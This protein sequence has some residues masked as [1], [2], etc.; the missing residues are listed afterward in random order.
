MMQNDMRMYFDSCLM[1]TK[2]YVFSFFNGSFKVI[3]SFIQTLEFS[4]LL[5][6]VLTRLDIRGSTLY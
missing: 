1:L 5:I 6:P 2:Q 3:F 4:G